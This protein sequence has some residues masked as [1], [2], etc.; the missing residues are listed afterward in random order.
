MVYTSIKDIYKFIE[1]GQLEIAIP[2]TVALVEMANEE[3]LA[4]QPLFKE[5]LCISGG[6]K[7][8]KRGHQLGLINFETYLLNCNNFSQRL[9]NFLDENK[10]VLAPIL[11]ETMENSR[12][13]N[14][15]KRDASKQVEIILEI[16]EDFDSYS[17][18][19]IKKLFFEIGK[20]LDL[21]GELKLKSKER[22][23]VKLKFSLKQEKAEEL[24]WLVETGILESFSVKNVE[25]T[26]DE[27]ISLSI[28]FIKA[29]IIDDEIKSH[30][31]LEVFL[32]R[33]NPEIEIVASGFSVE[34]GLKVISE[35]TPDIVFL[36]VELPDGT[37][38]DLLSQIGE[39][40][41]QTILI[42]P[43]SKYAIPAIRSGVVDFLLKP[44]AY[45]ELS[46]SITRAKEMME[47]KLALEQLSVLSTVYQNLQK[48]SFKELPTRIAI[49]DL[50][51]IHYLDVKDIIYLKKNRD[52]TEFYLS[53]QPFKVVSSLNFSEYVKLFEPYGGFFQ[54][55][56]SHIVNLLCVKKFKRQER[57]IILTNHQQISVYL[58]SYDS[59]LVRM[60][61]VHNYEY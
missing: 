59:L 51:G 2:E 12:E 60:K 56:K 18:E 40:N 22:G 50:K 4:F 24:L 17:S 27:P 8:C 44:I 7:R 11:V 13:R 32:N 54:V 45:S 53:H 38:F 37:G 26:K 55:N 41:F 5:I 46:A 47:E 43:D 39:N 49:S 61:Q 6:Y 10:R 25:V 14:G 33:Q 23:S 3:N 48:M 20:L 42:S 29:V 16:D 21:K 9:L 58:S 15:L 19:D 35:N 36:D 52:Y 34:E 31:V 1:D 30:E 28:P 57:E